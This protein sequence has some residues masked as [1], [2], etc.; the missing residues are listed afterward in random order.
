M[1]AIFITTAVNWE[2]L[3]F[4]FIVQV[5]IMTIISNGALLERSLWV[6][7]DFLQFILIG[8]SQGVVDVHQQEKSSSK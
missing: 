8:H 3:T 6:A 2:M 4:R 1:S 7:V 5:L